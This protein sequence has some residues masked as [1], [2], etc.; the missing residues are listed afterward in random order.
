MAE[1]TEEYKDEEISVEEETDPNKK[2]SMYEEGSL[3]SLGVAKT[4][5]REFGS[6]LKV[7]KNDELREHDPNLPKSVVWDFAVLGTYHLGDIAKMVDTD[8]SERP[9]LTLM[10]ARIQS[11]EKC[12]LIVH[13]KYM[14]DELRDQI[15]KD[16]REIAEKDDSINERVNELMRLSVM[17]CMTSEM[18]V[19]VDRQ[20]KENQA[21]ME[22]EM[23]LDEESDS[24]IE[25]S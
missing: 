21:A 16:V 7:I 25:E 18:A 10:I 14:K 3:I 1:K 17:A 4:G 6:V 24:V 5:Y 9:P 12:Y 20:M 11:S 22:A 8:Y 23:A 13:D 19:S 15:S 2:S